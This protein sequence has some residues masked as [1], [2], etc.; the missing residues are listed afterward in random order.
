MSDVKEQSN[1]VSGIRKE[2]YAVPEVSLPTNLPKV[3][4]FIP[5]T[6]NERLQNLLQEATALCTE[7]E[8]Y[9]KEC[10]SKPSKE[11]DALEDKTRS[12]D[13]VTL[14]ENGET[15]FEFSER[16]TTDVV[17]AKMLGM[18]AYMLKA[19]RVL[20]VG[21]FTGYGTLT[22]AESLPA[23][24][25]I[26]ALEIDPFLKKFSEPLFKASPHGHKIN[27]Q[28]GDALKSIQEWPVDDKIDMVFIDADK[29]SYAAYY[30]TIISRGLLAP[31][32]VIVVDNTLF[33][34]TPYIGKGKFDNHGWNGG[35][36]AIAN[37]NEYVAKDDRVEQVMLPVRDGV[38]IVRL[39]DQMSDAVVVPKSEVTATANE[40]AV[41][42]ENNAAT[43]DILSRMKLDGKN[44][45]VTGGGQGIGRAFAHA[46]SEAGASVCIVDIA[47]DRAEAVAQEIRAKGSR[48]FALKVDCTKQ[49][50]IKKMIST[51]VERWGQLHIAVN[52]AGVNKNSAAEDTPIEDWDLTFNLNTRGVFLCCQEEAKHMLKHGYG[53]IINTASMATLLVP[54]PQKQAAY[55]CSKAAV[56][57][58]T[59][60]LACE[61]ADKGLNVN[62]ISP[63]IVDTPL[64][65]ENPE[66]NKLAEVWLEQIPAKR[67]AT[68][69]DLQSAI[70]YLASDS[71][72]YMIGHNMV[73][74]GGQSLW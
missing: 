14:S 1:S 31:G 12:S 34:G 44:A 5:D 54:H 53:K 73:I 42:I 50:E 38:T 4:K 48:S 68:T 56:V 36:A 43:P 21:M 62:C 11:T 41:T 29:G 20:E 64:I 3:E 35:G 72:S 74:E 18:F 32:G 67:L 13:W 23:D 55:N 8:T 47:Q 59:Q 17:E 19:K 71:S 52:N 22:I 16:W 37:F 9:L 49:D 24:G 46:L 15:M 70:V 6:P 25:R 61:W 2:N 39:K 30:E 7:S 40:G 63:G 10:T 57:K 27:V 69:D 65:W 45:I 33:K 51:V 26:T 28:I 66:L 58:M 60:S